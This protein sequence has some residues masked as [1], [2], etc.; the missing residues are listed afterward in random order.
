[1]HQIGDAADVIYFIEE[2]GIRFC[3]TSDDGKE[4]LVRD[5]K[6]G[7]WFGFIGCFGSGFRP[8]DAVSLEDSRLRVISRRE[9]ED[10][11]RYDPA[12]W[13]AIAGI[14]AGYVSHFYKTYESSVFL[15]LEKRLE[16]TLIQLS[17]WQGS[18]TLSMSQSDLAA[19]LGVTKEAVGVNLN[20][21]KAKGAVELGYRSIH[22][23][24][25]GE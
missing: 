15:P 11:G 8:N 6:A 2:G 4:L 19:I 21:L 24:H 18:K 16:E 1:M 5:L 17:K 13:R 22:L 20:I 12:L 3:S 14:L 7:E 23:R 10:I 25:L 9:I